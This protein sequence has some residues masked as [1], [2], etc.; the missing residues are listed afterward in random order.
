M[1][2][3]DFFS[4]L[5]LLSLAAGCA[6]ASGVAPLAAAGARRRR[7]LCFTKSS[8]FIHSVVKPGPD[9]A[10][11]LVDRTLTALGER[12]GFD[13]TCTKDGSVFTRDGLAAFDAF[14]FFTSGMLDV[15]GE[16]KHPPMPPGGKQALLDAVR[17]GKGFIGVHAA[18][19][20]FHTPTEVPDR[21]NRYRTYYPNVDPY[22]AMLGGEFINHGRQ[23]SGRV[24]VVDARFPGMGGFTDGAPRMGEWYSLKEFAPDMHVLMV[25]DTE[26]MQDPEYQRGPYPV[27][28]A[29]RHGQGRVLYTALGHREDEWADP[30]FLGLLSGALRWAF[31]DVAAELP[32]N[33][34]AAAPRH[35]DIPPRRPPR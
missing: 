15:P 6:R 16:D 28:W 11:S 26:G 2:R 18:S 22:V 3:R 1:H 23:Q 12:D 35:A 34:A 31:G 24:R 33:L 8:G 13:V 17:G 30:A 29:R 27:T 32:P 7:L 19:D 5:A 25:L 20:S 4:R 10:P 21:S 9:G 14:L